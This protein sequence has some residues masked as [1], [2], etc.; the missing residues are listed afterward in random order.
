[1][2]WFS[3]KPLDLS[4]INVVDYPKEKYFSV[5]HP[6]KQIVLHH[7]VSGPGIRGDLKTWL[8]NE[9]RVGT[10]IIIDRDGTPNQMFSSRFWAYHTGKGF[11]IDQASIGIEFDNWGGLIKGNNTTYNFGTAR[12]PKNKF[13]EEGK[14]YAVYGNSVDVPVT[15]YPGGWRGF[16]YYESY[17]DEQIQTA[18]ELI[19]L[20]KDRY[21]IPVHYNYDMWD[22]S[23]KALAGEPGIWAHVS[24]RPAKDKQD[25]HPQP[26]LKKMLQALSVIN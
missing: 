26:E 25:C 11:T 22:I 21:N 14:F 10:C 15:H 17:T 20:W 7:T 12:K 5:A 24:Y 8:A 19:L 16:E 2:D 13:I 3:L 1:M 23:P 9:H 18:G 4:K 6:K